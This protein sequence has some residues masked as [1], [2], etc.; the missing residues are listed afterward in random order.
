MPTNHPVA[1]NATAANQLT[2]LDPAILGRAARARKITRSHRRFTMLETLEER[3][4]FSGDAAP[5]VLSIARFDPVGPVADVSPVT[6]TATFSEA[7][8]GV[9]PTDFVLAFTGSASGAITTVTPVNASVYNITVGSVAGNGTLGLNLDDD[10]SIR[11]ARGSSLRNPGAPAA[12]GPSSSVISNGYPWALAIA[13]LNNDGKPDAVTTGLLGGVSVMLGNGDATFQPQTNYAISDEEAVPASATIAD[14]NGDGKPDVLIAGDVLQGALEN[15]VMLFLGNGDGTLSPSGTFATGTAFAVFT[16]D[17][18]GDGKL[19]VVT[20]NHLDDSVSVLLG[21]G[22]GTFAAQATFAVGD[23]PYFGAVADLNGD[24]F[25]D[26]AASNTSGDSVSVLMGKGDGTFHPQTTMAVGDTPY[27]V[28]LADLN[29]DGAFDVVVANGKDNNV[30]VMLGNGNGTFAAQVTYAT[31]TLPVAMTLSDINGDGKADVVAANFQSGSVSVLLGNSNGTFRPQSTVVGAVQSASLVVTDINSDGRPDIVSANAFGNALIIVPGSGNGDF[32][33]DK[34]QVTPPGGVTVNGAPSFTKGANQTLLED[35]GAVS[36]TG[37]ATAIASGPLDETWQAVN[38]IVNNDNPALFAA[39]PMIAADGKLSFTPAPD[40]FG[41]ATVTVQIH[42]DGGTDNGGVDTS[43]SQ[44]FVINVTP[45]NDAP[46]FTK[47]A[48]VTVLEDSGA[49]SVAWATT[50]STGPANESAQALNFVISNSNNG[51]FATQPTITPNGTLSFTP[52]TNA[53]GSATVTVQIHDNGGVANGGVDTS[54]SQT[55][56]ISVTAVNDA[57]SFVKGA[58]QTVLEDSGA[59]SVSAW[60]TSLSKGPINEAGQALNF[61]VSNNNNALF[62]TQPTIAANG[63]LTFTPAANANGSATVTVQIHDDGGVANGGVDTSAAQTFTINV[64]T[65][66]DAPSFTKGANQTVLEDS[67]AAVVSAWATALSK[68]PTNESGQALN[69]IVTNSNNA[70]FSSQPTIAADGTLTFIPA[71]HT[72]GSATVTVQIHDNG[73]VANGGVDTSAAQTFIINVSA[74]NNV[75]AFT[76]GGD[77]AT[78]EDAGAQVVTPWATAIS[79]GVGD[80][81]QTLN[82]VVSNDNNALFSTQPS[83]DANGKLTYTTAPNAHGSATVTVQLHDDGGVA[84]GGVDTSASQTFT[85]NV[86]AANDAPVFT[87]GVNQTVLEDSG[88]ASLQGWATAMSSGPGDESGQTLGF[89]VSN[90]NSALFAVQPSVAA[91]GTL[92]FTPASNAFGN[93][94]VTVQLHDNGGVANGGADTSAAQTFTISVLAVNDG[95]TFTKGADQTVNEDSGQATIS[96]WATS[97]VKG[98]VNES[99]QALNFILSNDNNGLFSTQPSVA[100]DGTLTF[101][102]ALNANGSATV[103]VQIHDNGGAANGGADTSVIQTFVI[104]VTPINDAPTF[105]KSADQTVLED[106]GTSSISAWASAISKGAANESGQTLNF[107]VSNNNNSLFSTQPTIAADGTLT[108]TPAPNAN[109]SATV[110]VQLH[111]NG[112]TASGGADTS[113]SQTFVIHVTPVNDAPTFTK[114][115]NVRVPNTAFAYTSP[116]GWATGISAGPADESGQQLS[117]VLD[118]FDPSFFTVQPAINPTT[119]VLTFTTVPGFWPGLFGIIVIDVTLH[120][121]G[122]T[123]NGGVDSYTQTFSIASSLVFGKVD[124]KRNIKLHVP[125]RAARGGAT[126]SIEGKGTGLV[127]PTLDGQFDV[128]VKGTDAKSILKIG[129]DKVGSGKYGLRNLIIGED[130]ARTSIGAIKARN[131]NFHGD[132][133]ITGSVAKATLG[134]ITGPSV[135]EIGM[136]TSSKGQATLTFGRVRDLSIETETPIK[137]LTA[138]D[139]LDT[140][141]SDVI[142]SPWIGSIQIKGNRGVRGDFEAGLKLSGVGAPDGIALRQFTAAGNLAESKWSIGGSIGDIVA[143]AMIDSAIFAGLSGGGQVLPK[144]LASFA[145]TASISSLTVRGSSREP[146][147]VRSFVAASVLSKVSLKIVDTTKTGVEFGLAADKIKDFNR[148]GLKLALKNLDAAKDNNDPT[149]GGDFVLRTV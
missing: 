138:I 72:S 24:G 130:E 104:N 20:T 45:V 86:A 99:S 109:G 7:V 10:N 18:N 73:G 89:I 6:F 58:D 128:V 91:D 127:V 55:F 49:A 51:L 50:L 36:V 57:P 140:R 80:T 113:T 95:P 147:F 17:F 96:A 133:L 136:P 38:F 14:V 1:L 16:A 19:D 143:G 82:F 67:G 88:A 78:L 48:N 81:G 40:A 75:P 4:L 44:T 108:Y 69:F 76:K 114:G 90:D 131:A 101:T 110:T 93:A 125:T 141:D 122:G 119:G 135:L 56:T 43:L 145:S 61:L 120:D 115:A 27:S 149:L 30:G 53:N 47:G 46:A 28:G 118:G 29:G 106:S 25:L 23:R 12:F 26:L 9:D 79:A 100:A 137:S 54:A 35:S 59:V 5:Y 63:T 111:D 60:A 94:I 144:S 146:S 134:D 129:A 84:N 124:N 112:G 126:F 121:S 42:D 142:V 71:L 65:V 2:Q 97:L 117:F 116:T 105:T 68:G 11:N 107:V 15:S 34:Y 92:T 83:I 66:N 8:T 37:W 22:N 123:A 98:P 21:N 70:L 148:A 41:T 103:T 74:I 102:P 32:V 33:G 87:K 3:R 132:V 39:Q 85:I 52:A 13:D 77:Q 64:T 62:A 31:G 139:W